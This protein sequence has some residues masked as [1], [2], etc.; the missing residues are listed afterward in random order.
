M[1]LQTVRI[2]QASMLA[3]LLALTSAAWARETTA[4]PSPSVEEFATMRDGVK[5]AADVY[6]PQ[7]EGPWPV[8]LMRTPYGKGNMARGGSH[9]RYTDAGYVY[10]VQDV[11]GKGNSEGEYIPFHHD[12]E[13]GYDTVE[14]AAKQPWSNGKIGMTGA[15]AMGI[16][17]NLA[18][19]ANPPSLEA[20]YVIVAPHMRFDEASFVGGVFKQADVGNWMERQGAG[21]QVPDTKRRV[22]WD[23]EWK[24]RDTAPNLHNITIPM[25]NVGGWYDIFAYGLR[26]YMYLQN[27]GAPGA[28]GRQK[29]SMGPFGHGNLSGDLAY[30]GADSLGDT[31]SDDDEIRWFN[32]WLKG[33]DNGIMDEPP[34]SYYMMASAR[35][36]KA[37][38]LNGWQT[39]ETW[40]PPHKPTRFYLQ[41]GKKLANDLPPKNAKSISYKFDPKNPVPTVGGANL[42]FER[43]PMDQRAIG[44]RADYLRFET[45]TLKEPVSI[46]GNVTVE[47]WAATD[48]PDTDF[49]AKLI[50]VYPDGYEA[51]VLDAPIRARYREGRRAE[52]VK[53]MVPGE[54]VQLEI[55]LWHTAITF[56]PGHKI[57]L[58]ITSSSD[59]RFE[60][61]D[62]SG[63]PP[64]EAAKPRVATNTI[65]LDAGHPSALV[66]PILVD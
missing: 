61:N 65:L 13:D 14:W 18:A 59:P 24:A 38:D 6:K 17:T 39:S 54:P 29:L 56:E 45:A 58:H 35:K 3:M 48:G 26:N 10:V 44:E 8:V 52:D 42:T 46:A 43:G 12:R 5:L 16:A 60:V 66:L 40:P 32:Y 4:K 49:I 47:L 57:A 63:T 25:F 37:S 50:D 64:G 9:M 34:V 1:K 11:R 2:W 53:M 55:D 21:D 36:E 31:R 62:N 33:E 23:E 19:T 28:K 20:A 7:G 41:P 51:I 15:S 22:L 27:F 30:P